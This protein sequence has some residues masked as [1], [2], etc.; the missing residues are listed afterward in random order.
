MQATPDGVVTVSLTFTSTACPCMD[1]IHWDVRERL[2]EIEEIE[3]VTIETVWD[4]P[5]TTAMISERGR[6]L[7]ADCGV[8]T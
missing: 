2:L 7:L 3:E 8:A 4:P 5:W 6:R 1:F